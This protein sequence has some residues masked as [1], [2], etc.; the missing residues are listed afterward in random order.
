[1]TLTL[2][3]PTIQA[4]IAAGHPVPERRLRQLIRQ[5]VWSRQVRRWTKL[6]KVMI[7][8]NR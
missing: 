2:L 1:M 5:R 6:T 4:E 7:E 3:A 8:E